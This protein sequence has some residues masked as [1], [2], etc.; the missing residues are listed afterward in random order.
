[1]RGWP[2]LF[3]VLL[4]VTAACPGVAMAQD[5]APTTGGGDNTS[6]LLFL[7]LA[8][9]NVLVQVV[10]S[11]LINGKSRVDSLLDQRMKVEREVWREQLERVAKIAEANAVGLA[12]TR[13]ELSTY[14]LR[15]ESERRIEGLRREF[16]ADLAELRGEV[17]ALAG[18]LK[19]LQKTV[20][21][22]LAV[23]QQ[24][25]GAR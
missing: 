23:V 19:E 4:V 10:S 16:R 25:G 3:M 7:G 11:S 2:V 1:M 13:E 20:A 17:K 8:A 21:E 12:R 9:T 14:E 22:V 24:L 6:V 5:A 18:E 15:S